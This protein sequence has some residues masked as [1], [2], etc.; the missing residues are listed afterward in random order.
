MTVKA[1]GQV[2]AWAAS[3]YG[4]G[5]NRSGAAI[6]KGDIM[7]IDL[8]LSA[9]ETTTDGEGPAGKLGNF[10]KPTTAGL[11]AS[12]FVVAME[13]AADNAL[14]KFCLKGVVK[15]LVHADVLDGTDAHDVL[16]AVNAS[17]VLNLKGVGELDAGI[18][19]LLENTL[20]TPDALAL[21][22]FNGEAFVGSRGAIA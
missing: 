3:H 19:I 15:A 12:I 11:F 10:I 8:L 18:A 2:G 13:D 4:K 22:Y 9:A 21:V 17:H 6:S 14:F 5:Y 20:S 7:E 1:I 16:A